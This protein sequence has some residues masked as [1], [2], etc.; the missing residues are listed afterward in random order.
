MASS[1]WRVRDGEFGM[2]SS[3]WR[4]DHESAMVLFVFYE[5][6]WGAIYKSWEEESASC[7]G[8]EGWMDG[9]VGALGLQI[10]EPHKI[11][12]YSYEFLR[13]CNA[14]C[15]PQLLPSSRIDLTIDLM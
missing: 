9:W 8:M 1:G 3:G 12:D 6:S 10:Y 15:Q 11:C 7:G 5:G 13:S 2:A 14:I 4:R